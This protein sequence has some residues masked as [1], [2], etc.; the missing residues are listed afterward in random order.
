MLTL[1]KPEPGH[2]MRYLTLALGVLGAACGTGGSGGTGVGYA[3]LACGVD[4][5]CP[6]G[7][8]CVNNICALQYAADTHDAG[9]ASDTGGSAA[10]IGS[11]SSGGAVDGG[12]SSS[13]GQ[14]DGGGSSSGGPPGVC[15]GVAGNCYES[16]VIYDG[17]KVAPT[18]CV[19]TGPGADLDFVAVWRAGKVMAVGK[20][21]KIAYKSAGKSGCDKNQHNTIDDINAL[22]GGFGDVCQANGKQLKIAD[23][24]NA[25]LMGGYLS[26]GGGHVEVQFAACEVQGGSDP[27]VTKCSGQGPL[28]AVLPGDEIDVYEF[29]QNYKQKYGFKCVC[30]DEGFE[31][32]LRK[33]VGQDA[34]SLSLGGASGSKTFVV[35]KN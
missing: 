28:F 10:D 30:T 34:G 15:T 26:L 25:D 18:A 14:V 35:P 1:S 19:G 33:K 17:S 23:C 7:M 12:G 11:A 22:A 32:D 31:L 29:G 13:G 2:S 5:A 20:L 8:V 9:A 24:K 4:G 3:P 16:A 27:S 21:G 6:N